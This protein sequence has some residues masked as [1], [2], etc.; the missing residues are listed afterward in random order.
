VF[1]LGAGFGSHT[2]H[3]GLISLQRVGWVSRPPKPLAK[4]EG[5]THHF[6][7]SESADYANGRAFARPFANP[8]YRSAFTS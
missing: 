5:V 4:A 7:A 3:R 2:P 6:G 8:P 1:F